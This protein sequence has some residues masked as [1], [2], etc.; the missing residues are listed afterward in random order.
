MRL[1]SLNAWGGNFF[2]PLMAYLAEMRPDILCLQEVTW[3]A[4]PSPDRLYFREHGFDLV[5]HSDLFAAVGTILPDHQAFFAMATE[6]ELVDDKGKRYRSRFGLASFVHRDLSVLGQAQ[7][8][9]HADF[10]PEGWGTP[11]VP[12]S[13]HALRLF[14]WTARR[15]F[16]V[17]HLHG[18]RDP[19][20]K[21][22]TPAR[23]AQAE[24]ALK[25]IARLRRPDEPMIF[26]GDLNLLPNSESFPIWRAAGLTDLVTTRGFTDTRTALYQ[27]PGRYAD[28]LL[29]SP[30][31]EVLSFDVPAEPVVSDHR[32]LVLEF[33]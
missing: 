7:D 10:D 29:V 14:D 31:I 26:G 13:L 19:E 21:H 28:Y 12:R 20:G 6:G 15:P 18:L 30:E 22:D 2:E 3:P 23:R 17:A 9:V 24:R 25:I 5:Q 27:K 16:V 4:E 1:I 32:A 33:R 11:P 8:F